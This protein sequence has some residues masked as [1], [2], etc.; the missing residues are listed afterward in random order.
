MKT[1]GKCHTIKPLS[2]FREDR[3]GRKN[4]SKVYHRPECRD[5][6]KLLREQLVIAKKQSGP[7]PE[8]CE[9]CKRKIEKLVVDHNHA[10]GKFRG[11]LCVR[12]NQ[13][14]G[15]LGDTWEGVMTA[16]DYL[17]SKAE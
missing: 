6:E 11:W 13:G 9:C 5:C 4:N 15:K 17:V 1:C 10:T 3:Q 12:C 8:C 2:D 14:I 7:K 16:L